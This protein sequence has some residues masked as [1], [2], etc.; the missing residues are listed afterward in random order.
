[1]LSVVL[2]Q[3]ENESTTTTKTG[4]QP[5]TVSTSL[6]QHGSVT[7]ELSNSSAITQVQVGARLRL[8]A[9]YWGKLTTDPWVIRTVLDC[10]KIEFTSEPMQAQLGPDNKQVSPAEFKIYDTE[11][12]KMIDKGAICKC[13]YD[14]TQFVSRLVLVPKKSGEMR[15]DINLKALNNF[16][17]YLHF[18]MENINMLIDLLRPSD[19]IATIDLQDAYF[20]IP[21][22]SNYSKYLCFYWNGILYEFVALP[23]GLSLAPHIFTKL[24]K[25]FISFCRGKAIRIIIFLGDIAVL[26][27]SFTDWSDKLSFV[28]KLSQEIG[29]VINYEKSELVSRQL[30]V[31]IGS[32]ID[33]CKMCIS[34][35]IDKITR[36]L[37]FANDVVV[38]FS[39][40]VPVMMTMVMTM[41]LK[42]L[43]IW[44]LNHPYL[45]QLHLIQRLKQKMM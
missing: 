9:C 14:P 31:Y 13:P 17:D 10:Y 28:I 12:S 25:P 2:V 22:H 5:D 19:F 36:I 30:A 33:S 3:S 4:K 8:F 32:L 45:N 24:L 42:S 11:V 41:M 15:P 27:E 26:G 6:L 18:K 44:M 7:L 43:M 38:N 37:K 35:P 40:N 34:L 21:I 16:V 23:F 1:M 29:F 20:T 39:Q